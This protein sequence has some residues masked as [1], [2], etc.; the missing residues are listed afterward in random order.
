MK[1][2]PACLG[3]IS[4]DFAEIPI[5]RDENVPYVHAQVVQPGNAR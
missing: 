1:S 3:E 4:L 2:E 5:R